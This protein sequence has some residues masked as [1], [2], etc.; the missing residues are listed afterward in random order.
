MRQLSSQFPIPQWRVVYTA[1]GNTLA[2]A[3]IEDHLGIIEHALYWARAQSKD[4]AYYLAAILNAPTLGRIVRPYQSVGAFG[5]RHFDK[6]VWL[7]PI[8]RYDPSQ[9]THCL[10]R[11]LAIKA[12][13]QATAV[14]VEDATTFQMARTVIREQLDSTGLASSMDEAVR[15]ILGA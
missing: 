7:A 11:D 4:E 9:P 10:L 6:Y 5:P 15:Q 14:D 13:A 2:A 8:P 12:Q 1:S 3:I